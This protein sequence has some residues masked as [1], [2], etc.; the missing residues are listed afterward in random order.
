MTQITSV[1]L[2]VEHLHTSLGIGTSRPRLSWAVE[3]DSQNWYQKG[4]EI[5][6]YGA[7]GQLI[8]QTGQIESD[9]SVLISWPFAPLSSRQ[10]LSA[11]VRIW[12]TDGVLSDW[13]EM[14]SVEAG[15]LQSAD[16]QAQFITPA[17]DEDATKSNPAPYLRREFELREGIAS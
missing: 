15:L 7:N 16:W 8:D 14:M 11:R 4:Y 5:E 17:W 13:S 9:Q 1:T 10:R 6:I 12:G 3:T 2:H